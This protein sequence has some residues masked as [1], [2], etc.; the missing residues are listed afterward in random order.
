MME[1][2]CEKYSNSMNRFLDMRKHHQDPKCPPQ[3]KH[4]SYRVC[5][6]CYETW[7]CGKPGYETRDCVAP[8][9]GGQK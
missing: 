1:L 9:V 2:S 4:E 8:K 3:Y 6:R 7:Y 5:P